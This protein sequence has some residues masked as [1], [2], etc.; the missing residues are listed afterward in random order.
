MPPR[1]LVFGGSQSRTKIAG[2]KLRTSMQVLK[3]CPSRQPVKRSNRL[4]AGQGRIATVANEGHANNINRTRPQPHLA[5]GLLRREAFC[6]SFGSGQQ[7]SLRCKPLQ[8]INFLCNT[9][10]DRLCNKVFVHF[11]TRF[12][13]SSQPGWLYQGVLFHSVSCPERPGRS[14]RGVGTKRTPGG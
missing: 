14:L 5:P 13:Q 4:M 1:P 3:S 8:C 10:E 12:V 2:R 6:F 7:R 11:H 9:L